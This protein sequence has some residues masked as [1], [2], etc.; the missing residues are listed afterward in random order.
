MLVQELPGCLGDK[1]FLVSKVLP[2]LQSAEAL[3]YLQGAYDSTVRLYS[4]G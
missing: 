3:S 1:D 2:Y 4:S